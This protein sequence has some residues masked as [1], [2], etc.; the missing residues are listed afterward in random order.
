MARV[1][2]ESHSVTHTLTI[3]VFSFS[4]KAGPHLPT[5]EGWKAELVRETTERKGWGREGTGKD[6]EG[7][8][9]L[10]HLL[11]TTLTTVYHHLHLNSSTSCTGC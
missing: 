6:G 2:K 1:L 9:E 3:P 4:A 7:E 5:Q 10:C 11:N 8:G